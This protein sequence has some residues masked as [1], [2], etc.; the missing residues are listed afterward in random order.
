[1]LLTI[2]LI[3]L[4]LALVGGGWGYGRYGGVAWSPIG[5]ILLLVLVLWL[6]GNV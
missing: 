4:V 1:M 2:L 5:L 3:L 6:T